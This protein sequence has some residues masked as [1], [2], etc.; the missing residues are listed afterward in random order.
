MRM[1]P[2]PV[3]RFGSPKTERES[4]RESERETERETERRRERER[5]RER[6]GKAKRE[7]VR[8][9]QTYTSFP[10]PVSF[11]HYREDDDPD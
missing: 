7:R 8:R 3:F 4:E 5:E 10:T 9:T 11:R 2:P 6:D 1:D